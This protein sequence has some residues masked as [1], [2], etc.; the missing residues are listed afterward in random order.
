MSNTSP[1]A[2]TSPANT[3]PALDSAKGKRKRQKKVIPFVRAAQKFARIDDAVRYASRSRGRLY[4]LA[5]QHPR[6]MVKEGR[7]TLVDLDVLDQILNTLPMAEI[8]APWR[9]RTKAQPE[10]QPQ[11]RKRKQPAPASLGASA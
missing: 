9:F 4:E 5:H 6:L 10:P 1:A 7:S 8:S 11:R 2:N 3:S